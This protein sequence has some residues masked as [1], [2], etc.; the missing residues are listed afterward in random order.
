[1]KTYF[2]QY[3]LRITIALALVA[4]AAFGLIDPTAMFGIAF[5]G[6]VGEMK[7]LEKAMKETFDA[8]Q[9]EI[10]KTQDIAMKAQEEVRQEGTLHG[11]TNEELKS[12]GEATRAL[13]AEMKAAKDS[14]NEMQQKLDKR[15][16]EEQKE[17]AD[18]RTAG[19]IVVE[20]EEIKEMMSIRGANSRPVAIKNYD[21]VRGLKAI[22]TGTVPSM[23]QPLVAGERVPGILAPAM[24]RLTIR[25]LLPVIRTSSNTI[26]F[27]T[28]LLFTN[29]AAPQG[30][31]AS[32]QAEVDG[33]P[34]PMSEITFQLDQTNVITLAHWIAASRQILDDAP[35]LQGYIDQRLGYGLKLEEERELLVSTGTSGELNGLI[36]QAT[37]FNGGATNQTAIDTLLKAFTQVSLAEYE[38]TACVLHPTDWQDIQLLKDT[39]GRYLFSDPHTVQAARIWAKDVVPTQSMTQGQFLTGA[40]DMGAAIY[41]REEM[42]IRISDQHQDFFTRNLI[43]VLCEERIALAVYRPAS[44]VTGALSYAG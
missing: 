44:F 4:G 43:A 13:Q 19:Q 9:V 6:E 15:H 22:I 35:A 12:L 25:D 33:Q 28:E 30:G 18:K 1:M 36:G 42:V 38:A 20:S 23:V 8:L 16:Q 17:K 21:A 37:A 29:A 24:R 41:D 14:F 7:A 27:T 5:L 40:F 34:K 10:R 39:Q 31:T 32:P 3:S 2:E 26:A 11:K